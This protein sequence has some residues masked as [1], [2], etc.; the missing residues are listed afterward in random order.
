VVIV[1]VT[2]SLVILVTL[3]VSLSLGGSPVKG[4]FAGPPLP[5]GQQY[6]SMSITPGELDLGSIIGTT[7]AAVARARTL[8]PLYLQY[9]GALNRKS[10]RVFCRLNN[11]L[12]RAYRDKR[13]DLKGGE[14]R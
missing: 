1:L 7:F 13:K 2:L 14:R 8:E 12:D 6:V 11:I 9:G 3:Q 10:P 5:C 4:K